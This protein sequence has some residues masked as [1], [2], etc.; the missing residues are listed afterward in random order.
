M[1][2]EEKDFKIKPS[3]RPKIH[4][5]DQPPVESSKGWKRREG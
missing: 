5:G 2:E 4:A 3:S 1:E